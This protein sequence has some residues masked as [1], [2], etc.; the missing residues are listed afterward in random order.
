MYGGHDSKRCVW[1]VVMMVGVVVCV[2]TS[3]FCGNGVVENDEVC[4]C[5][6]NCDS[7][8]CCSS[9]CTLTPGSQCR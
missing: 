2:A 1:G 7:D 6:S 3:A 5:G 8:M 4:D 9:N